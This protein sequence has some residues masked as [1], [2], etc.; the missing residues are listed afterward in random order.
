L[1]ENREGGT[2]IADFTSPQE[3]DPKAKGQIIG[4]VFAHN[5]ILVLVGQGFPQKAIQENM[6]IKRKNLEYHLKKLE[7]AGFIRKI[8]RTKPLFFELTEAGKQHIANKG[9]KSLIRCEN[10]LIKIHNFSV[11]M[12]LIR[13]VSQGFWEKSW[14]LKNWIKSWKN[15]EGWGVSVEKTPKTLTVNLQP[16]EQPPEKVYPIIYRMAF[17]VADYLLKFGIEVDSWE[18]RITKQESSCSDPTVRA[19]TDKGITVRQGLGRPVTKIFEADPVKP[20][21]A[22]IDASL[23]RPEIESN[24]VEYSRR[25]ILV[26]EMVKQVLDMTAHSFEFQKVYT[27][28]LKLHMKVMQG[29]DKTMRTINR[30]LSQRN[31]KEFFRRSP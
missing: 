14:E 7:V 13:D 21:V 20:A 11:E 23:G 1:R 2:A 28:N 9:Q 5:H 27:E 6:K 17:L 15:L 8:P 12:P 10:P 26:P 29:I 18:A 24:D 22:W 3:I 4:K 31:I 30:Q 19:L 16:T 25:Y